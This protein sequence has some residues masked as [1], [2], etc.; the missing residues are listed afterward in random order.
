MLVCSCSSPTSVTGEEKVCSLPSESA[1]DA[2]D[3]V[4]LCPSASSVS[5]VVDWIAR[6]QAARDKFK[7]TAAR[8]RFAS[9]NFDLFIL[10]PALEKTRSSLRPMEVCEMDER[11]FMLGLDDRQV[12]ALELTTRNAPHVSHQLDQPV[13]STVEI[14]STVTPVALASVTLNELTDM[15][16]AAAVPV[17]PT[18]SVSTASCRLTDRDV[19]E[20]MG[21]YAADLVDD[22]FPLDKAVQSFMNI[23]RPL[24]PDGSTDGTVLLPQPP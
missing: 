12:S 6:M 9:D 1:M 3:Q 22:I 18:T 14:P 17:K 2:T 7:K 4:S 15:S 13:F 11:N 21:V 23:S 5:Q 10:A 19:A 8:V 24:S 16:P 20:W